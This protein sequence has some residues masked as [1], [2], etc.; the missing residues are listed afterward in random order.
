MFD[1]DPKTFHHSS[2]NSTGPGVKIFFGSTYTVTKI[3][4]IP[5]SNYK[6]YLSHNENTIFTIIKEDG[7]KENCGILTGTNTED[8]TVADQTYEILCENRQG[9]GL[10]VWKETSAIWCPAEIE[11]YYSNRKS[12]WALLMKTTYRI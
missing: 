3:T 11:I 10:K 6:P 2:T 12:E 9:V 4:F 1:G 5:R 8:E 7:E